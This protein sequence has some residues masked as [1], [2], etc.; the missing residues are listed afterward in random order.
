MPRGR[1]P[2][3]DIFEGDAIPENVLMG[4]RGVD[5]AQVEAVHSIPAGFGRKTRL[6]RNK[7]TAILRHMVRMNLAQPKEFRIQAIGRGVH[8]R[9]AIIH[10]NLPQTSGTII[11]R[12]G[13]PATVA[14][15][16][17]IAEFIEQQPNYKHDLGTILKY[18]VKREVNP[19]IENGLYHGFRN[20]AIDARAL[21]EK[22]K[23]IKFK[24]EKI[25]RKKFYE[26][27]K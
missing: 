21:L 6:P 18:F 19:H 25:G 5:P 22:T 7:I 14:S 11:V 24:E 13:G 23:G 9:F 8:T 27:E 3:S 26:I 15:I 20:S 2:N 4:S 1:K 17:E 12:S 16:T 10:K